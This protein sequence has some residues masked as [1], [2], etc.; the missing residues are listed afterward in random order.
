MSGVETTRVAG[1]W[2][3]VGSH[4]S[5]VQSAGQESNSSRFPS[6]HVSGG[7]TIWLPH[8]VQALVHPSL[9]SVLPS[10]HSSSPSTVP[11]PHPAGRVVVVVVD[12]VLVVVVVDV[13]ELVVVVVVAG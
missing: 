4:A 6:S 12:V 2:V 10:S 5:I 9:G 7:V 3:V 8:T 11:L 13:V 1:S